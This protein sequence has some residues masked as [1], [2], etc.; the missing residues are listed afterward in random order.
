VL[1]P[2]TPGAQKNI[3]GIVLR[4]QKRG[5]VNEVSRLSAKTAGWERMRDWWTATSYLRGA[6]FEESM[7]PGLY[8]IEVSSPDNIGSY[9]LRIGTQDPTRLDYFGLVGD[10]FRIQKATNGWIVMAFV[11]P[12]LG[13][14][15]LL[16]VSL[17]VWFLWRRRYFA[18]IYARLT[19]G[20]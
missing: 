12:Y 19:E 11:T 9:A 6:S 5:N 15:L 8:R 13:V 16:G 14:P 1:V 2:A 3:S 17:A 7:E 18:R 10:M 4:V 20:K